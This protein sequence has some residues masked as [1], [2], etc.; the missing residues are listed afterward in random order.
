MFQIGDKIFYPTQGG[1]IIQTIEEKSI[2]GGTKLYYTINVT[3][4][5]MK[6]M[7]PIDSTE[8]VGLRRIVDPEELDHVLSTFY[9]G[10]TDETCNHHQRDRTNMTKIKRGNIYEGAEVIRDLMRISAKKTLGATEK[11]MLANAR[12]ILISEVVLV[13]GIPLDQ[14]SDLID[15]VINLS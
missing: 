7:I 14:A 9:D 5:N 12:Q 15:R 2:L 3:L 4:R 8:K 6:V 11:N 13:K 1:G 10:E